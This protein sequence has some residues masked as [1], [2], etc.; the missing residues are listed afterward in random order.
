MSRHTGNKDTLNA[1]LAQS[2]KARKS[3]R[4][5]RNF[6]RSLAGLVLLGSIVLLVLV[7]LFI[8]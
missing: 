6:S 5:R 4:I 7:L 1:R 2:L 3:L 8:R